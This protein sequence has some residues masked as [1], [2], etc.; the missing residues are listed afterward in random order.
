MF[1]WKVKCP[2]DDR[3]IRCACVRDKSIK[4]E[5]PQHSR[6]SRHLGSDQSVTT[7]GVPENKR[8]SSAFSTGV[9]GLISS[10]EHAPQLTTLSRKKKVGAGCRASQWSFSRSVVSG[11]FAAVLPS[12]EV[13]TDRIRR[14]RIPRGQT[15]NH[16]LRVR[17]RTDGPLMPSRFAGRFQV[18]CPAKSDCSGGQCDRNDISEARLAATRHP[19]GT[20]A[21]VPELRAFAAGGLPEHRGSPDL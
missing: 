8:L 17:S 21:G 5:P 12:I 1:L 2:Q 4:L 6:L 3:A 7:V 13:G 16:R 18:R 19:A 10:P 11:L 9:S 20:P 15:R 14:S